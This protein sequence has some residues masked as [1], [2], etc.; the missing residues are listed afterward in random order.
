MNQSNVYV[1]ELPKFWNYSPQVVM[2]FDRIR[3]EIDADE[4]RSYDYAE[5]SWFARE[6]PRYY[7]HHVDHVAF[8][9]KVFIRFMYM[10]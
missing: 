6:F 1:P 4:S 5:F 3:F 8:V 10:K 7:R 9:S 2:F